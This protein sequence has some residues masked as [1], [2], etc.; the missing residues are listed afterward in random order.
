MDHEKRMPSE[1]AEV[2]IWH[3][4]EFNLGK[5]VHKLFKGN[6]FFLIRV[7]IPTLDI[8][9]NHMLVTGIQRLPR[10]LWDCT[11]YDSALD[12]ASPSSNIMTFYC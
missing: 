1:V 7:D 2:V 5:Y 9:H 6:H 11:S 10:S 12:S 4:R 8:G 3:V